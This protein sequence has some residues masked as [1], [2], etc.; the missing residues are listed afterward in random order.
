MDSAHAHK[1]GIY[2]HT[3]SYSGMK[4]GGLYIFPTMK[5]KLDIIS[6]LHITYNDPVPNHQI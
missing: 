4:I 6:Y 1:H 3:V 5:L 2:V